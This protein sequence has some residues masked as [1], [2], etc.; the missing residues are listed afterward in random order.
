VNVYYYPWYD[1]NRH[2]QEGFLRSFLV[3]EQSPQLGKYS[4]RDPIAINQ[5]I[6]WS[7]TFGIDNW[8]CSWWGPDSWEDAT[9]RNYISPKMKGRKVTYCLFYESAGLL[10]VT[11]GQILFNDNSIAKIRSHFAYIADNYFSDPNYQRINGRP[12][13]YIY[14]TR[15]FSYNYIQAFQLI[16]QD[17][18]TKGY[19][20]FL[21][22]DEV[23]WGSPNEQRIATLDAVTAYNM[24]GPPQYAGYPAI[25]N[26]LN[27]VGSIYSQYKSVTDKYKVGFIPN[28]MPGFNDRG[29][30]LQTNHYIISNQYNPDSSF[31]STFN[32]FCLIANQYVDSVLNMV[33]VTSFNEWHEDTQ[34]EPT[35]TALPTDKDQSLKNSY[36]LGYSYKGYGTELL[37]VI[38]H[39]FKPASLGVKSCFNSTEIL[40]IQNY[41]NPFNSSTIINYQLPKA[42]KVKLTIFDLVGKEIATIVDEYKLP[43][44]YSI[45]FKT[46]NLSSGLYFYQFK[47]NDFISM[48]KMIVTK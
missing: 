34:I 3:P 6:D 44:D 28:T 9:I 39:N 27:D 41:P 36:T 1:V 5:H 23:Y 18:L 10:P 11:N 4:C 48:K 13:V 7:E 2:W 21:I 24:H 12:V 35:N 14:L 19:N 31:S 40:L 22:G 42:G 8:I 17:M 15:I 37:Q 46:R 29:V 47:V 32:Q 38:L 20:I 45:E 26:F 43:G 33:T 25:T 16:R 30:R